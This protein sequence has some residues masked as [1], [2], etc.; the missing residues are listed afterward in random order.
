MIYLISIEIILVLA[1]I[2]VA[3]IFMNKQC[4]LVKQAL[5]LHNNQNSII[6]DI[7]NRQLK[8]AAEFSTML[9]HFQRIMNV[10]RKAK[11]DISNRLDSNQDM[12]LAIGKSL[13]DLGHNYNEFVAAT[14]ENFQEL[15]CDICEDDCSICPFSDQCEQ[16]DNV[17]SNNPN[18][19]I[20]DVTPPTPPIATQDSKGSV[21][22]DLST[23]EGVNKLKETLRSRGMPEIEVENISKAMIE[24]A[25]K[26]TTPKLTIVWDTKIERMPGPTNPAEYVKKSSVPPPQEEKLIDP[27]SKIIKTLENLYKKS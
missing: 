11:V 26:N 14:G 23:E 27:K 13:N 5:K 3:I 1:C 25:L 17:V 15:W 9:T 19:T 8:Q 21:E 22:V 7:T 6:C 24:R 10:I 4:D 18:A 12:I 2:G 16:I 20:G